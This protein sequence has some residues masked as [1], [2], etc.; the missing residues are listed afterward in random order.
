MGQ[1][2]DDSGITRYEI[3]AHGA[4]A[5]FRMAIARVRTVRGTSGGAGAVLPRH[6]RTAAGREGHC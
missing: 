5:A 6:E 2:R 1:P 4:D 3:T